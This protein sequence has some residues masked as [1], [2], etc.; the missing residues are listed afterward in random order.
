MT[1]CGLEVSGYVHLCVSRSR[2]NVLVWCCVESCRSSFCLGYHPG[3]LWA[4]L[5]VSV[6]EALTWTRCQSLVFSGCQLVLLCL[7]LLHSTF[8]ALFAL[9]I[10][11]LLHA[12]VLFLRLCTWGLHVI[13]TLV[14]PF[15]WPPRLNIWLLSLSRMVVFPKSRKFC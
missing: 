8:V 7:S 3:G 4:A 15:R 1:R 10:S 12:R 5:T 6:L 13:S 14:L 9:V 11:V 2:Y